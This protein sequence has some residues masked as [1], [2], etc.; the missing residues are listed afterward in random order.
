M[1]ILVT[2]CDDSDDSSCDES[3]DSSCDDSDDSTDRSWSDS[4]HLGLA[5]NC[6][7]TSLDLRI[8]NFRPRSTKLSLSLIDCLEGCS[9]LKSLTLTLNEYNEWKNDYASLLRERLGRN[10]SLSSL[11]LTFNF[12]TRVIYD[13][14][15]FEF[16][17]IDR[18]APNI[19]MKSFTL[20]INDFSSSGDCGLPSSVLWPNYKSLTTFDLTLNNCAEGTGNDLLDF[21]DVVMKVDSLRTLRLKINDSRSRSAYLQSDFSEM[22]EK[23]P[24]LELIELT[25]SCYGVGASSPE[26]LKWEK[27]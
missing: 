15:Y 27:Q 24:S 12:Y 7:L 25:I 6:T 10:T 20:T 8:N 11:T 5:R 13:D 18:F 4:L 3:D 2:T 17:D 16:D 14:S 22:V 19:S 1:F 23:S 21:L 26:T 9:S